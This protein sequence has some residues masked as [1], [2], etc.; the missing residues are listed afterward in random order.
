M[1]Q[2][3]DRIVRGEDQFE[4][5]RGRANGP[6]ANQEEVQKRGHRQGKINRGRPMRFS[7]LLLVVGLAVVLSTGR[8]AD[9]PKKP[10]GPPV[11][12]RL[13][14]SSSVRMIFTQPAVEMM[15]KYG[16]LSIPVD[17][18]RRIDFGF[19]YPEGAEETINDLITQLGDGNYKR[20]EAAMGELLAFRELAYPA[21][22]RAS[23]SSDAETAKRAGELLTKLED[24]LPPEKLKFRDSDLVT[25]V[26][27][28]ARG[29]IEAKTLQGHTPYFG[30]VKLQIAEVRSLRSVAFGGERTL[31]IDSG[32]HLDQTAA[33]LDTDVELTGDIPLEIV[34]S[35]QISLYRGGGYECGPKG[36][37]SYSNGMHQSGALLGRIGANGEVFVVGEK[38]NGTPKGTGKLYLR[39]A[40]S[41]WPQQA[42][43]SFKV[44][45]TPNP[46][47]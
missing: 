7:R 33:W 10:A 25:T 47:R 4:C 13:A 37:P 9:P 12:I 1:E 19:R 20:R 23:K 31:Q 8:A 44:T 42:T 32:K 39:L 24:K 11:E 36:H 18:I 46:A 27:F 45:I 26:D 28:T 22:K 14:D 30:D 15:T 5:G 21:L 3:L 40:H 43:G 41:P 17:E 2:R 29:R 35:G 6:A 16:K 38:Y 34:A